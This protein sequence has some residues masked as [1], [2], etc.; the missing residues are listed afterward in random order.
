MALIK[1]LRPASC[2]IFDKDGFAVGMM[3]FQL[4]LTFTFE[5]NVILYFTKKLNSLLVLWYVFW[6]FFMYINILITYLTSD[7]LVLLGCANW[8]LRGRDK[9]NLLSLWL[10]KFRLSWWY[11]QRYFKLIKNDRKRDQNALSS[12]CQLLFSQHV[13]EALELDLPL[14]VVVIC[15]TGT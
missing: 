13:G 12:V 6:S 11:K 4:I 8:T 14:V 2:K 15:T 3:N 9:Q 1:V 5:I 7:I 10:H